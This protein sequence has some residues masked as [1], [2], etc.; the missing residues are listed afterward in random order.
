MTEKKF[1]TISDVM[2]QSAEESM[3]VI[4]TIAPAI[5]RVATKSGLLHLILE[6]QGTAANEAEAV[7]I[8][9]GAITALMR[10]ALG[11]CMDDMKAILAAVNGLTVEEMG[12]KYTGWDIV[13]A[14]KAIITDKDFFTLLRSLIA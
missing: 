14:A 4:A 6:K 11:E 10:Y 1:R 8:V 13:N 2:S 3:A 5:E 7:E 9:E 12:E